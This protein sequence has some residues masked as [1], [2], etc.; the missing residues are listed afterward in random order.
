M[1]TR[2]KHSIHVDVSD[3]DHGPKGRGR[4][5]IGRA[6][7]DAVPSRSASNNNRTPSK[8]HAA[9]HTP[10]SVERNHQYQPQHDGVF[11]AIQQRQ[12]L[13]LNQ[14][15]AEANAKL[16]QQILGAQQASTSSQPVLV[17]T[18][19]MINPVSSSSTIGSGNS[20]IY[21]PYQGTTGQQQPSAR[22][23]QQSQQQQQQQ[24]HYPPSSG[25]NNPASSARTSQQV[26]DSQRSSQQTPAGLPDINNNGGNNTTRSA[27]DMMLL[28]MA[29]GEASLPSNRVFRKKNNNATVNNSNSNNGGSTP[30]SNNSN[31]NAS[32]GSGHHSSNHQSLPALQ[33]LVL[34]Q[35]QQQQGQRHSSSLQAV[36]RS[37]ASLMSLQQDTQI[38]QQQQQL[39]PPQDNNNSSNNGHRPAHLTQTADDIGRALEM[40][41]FRLNA[42]E[43]IDIIDFDASKR[44]YKVHYPTGAVQWLDLAKKP[45]R[46]L[47]DEMPLAH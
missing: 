29:G 45:V 5:Q 30:V 11:F 27:A 44:M 20:D 43:R 28:S 7:K 25:R 47:A 12:R 32:S 24:Q 4:H 41:S 33:P 46:A 31:I 8:P 38:K 36:V 2:Y 9:A 21:A 23:Q 1:L 39:Q 26:P 6:Q 19:L 42:W 10:D 15:L 3:N 34:Q 35:Q 17:P 18:N 13:E 37:T 40:F 14:L 22:K 16:Q